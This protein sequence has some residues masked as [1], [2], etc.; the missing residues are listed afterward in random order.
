MKVDI[1]DEISN[2]M[3][4]FIEKIIEDIGPRMPGSEEEAKSA[5][6]I[7]KEME[8]TCNDVVIEPFKL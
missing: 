2:Y 3:Y 1:P 8:K 4:D 7:K 6:Y 5:E